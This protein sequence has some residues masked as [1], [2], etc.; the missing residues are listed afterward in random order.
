[1]ISLQLE[2]L[3]PTRRDFPTAL[4]LPGVVY[5]DTEIFALEQKRLFASQWVCVAHVSSVPRRG[6]YL[7][8]QIGHESVAILRGDDGNVRAFHN[9]CRHRGSRLLD[10]ACGSGL[11]RIVCPYHAWSYQLDGNL[12]AAPQT[13]EQLD[14]SGLGLLPVQLATHAGLIFVNLDNKA[15]PLATCLKQ[16]PDLSR[17][18][19]PELKLGRRLEYDVAANWKLIGENYSEC[20][21]CPGAHPQLHKLTQL[22]G[23]QEQPMEMGDCFN[24]GPM[25]LRDG[26]TTMSSSGQRQLPLIPGLSAAE[27]R[28][29]H[30]YVIYPN[31]LLSPHPDYLLLHTLWPLAPGRTRVICEWLVTDEA[32]AAPT[33]AYDDVVGFWDA[34]NREDWMLCERT[35]LGVASSGYRPGP[36]Q[37]SEDCVHMFDR[38]YADR[39]AALL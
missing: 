28:Q 13:D 19:I 9:V 6:D 39:L 24:G 38:W 2:D 18:R 7:V 29:V 27:Q 12:L 21:H 34:V 8:R 15:A 20:Y 17:F 3:Q 4:T 30:Y 31:L 35:Q 16:L 36:Y 5:A 23:R 11:A 26:V 33:Q 32:L 1:M 25:R 37:T 10:A 22:I 14:R